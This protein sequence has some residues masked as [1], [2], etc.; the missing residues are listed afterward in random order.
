M[1][2]FIQFVDKT[3]VS[4]ATEVAVK[5]TTKPSDAHARLAIS[6]FWVQGS[7]PVCI[8]A[9][10]YIYIYICIYIYIY[11]IYI[12]IYVCMYVCAPI[13]YSIPPHRKPFIKGLGGFP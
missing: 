12:Y 7:F 6:L 10:I 8:Y 13:V 2:A 4:S 11:N 3:P 1:A 5:Q 9:Y